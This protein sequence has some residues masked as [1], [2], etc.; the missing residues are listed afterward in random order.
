MSVVRTAKIWRALIIASTGLLLADFSVAEEQVA[1]EQNC[2]QPGRWLVPA[3][4]ESLDFTQLMPRLKDKK[5]V[6][7]GEVHDQP[8]HH[9]WQ[10]QMVSALSA[11]NGDIA[12]AL[13][14]FPRRVQP[15]LDRWVAGELTRQQFLE[16]TD[17]FAVWGFAPELYMPLF[18]FARLNNVRMLAMNVDR[19]LVRKVGK[20]GWESVP[21]G[22]RENVS[23]PAAPSSA[24]VDYLWDIFRNHPAADSDSNTTSDALKREGPEFQSFVR[25]QTF[26]DRAMADAIANEVR[27]HP[28]RV[29]IAVLGSGHVQEGWGVAHQLSS[30]GITDVGSLLPWAAGDECEEPSATVADAVFGIKPNRD[31][32]EQSRPRLGVRVSENER[33]LVVS[34]VET[35]SIA[36]AAGIRAQDLLLE[37]AGIKLKTGQDLAA[38]VHRQPLGTWLPVLVERDGKEL[39]FI[40]RF[41]PAS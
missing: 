28:D 9:I 3:T 8:E 1:E 20:S 39:Q 6:L 11:S 36:S 25:S 38:V 26:W 22:E 2:P 30:Q 23:E 32:D 37:A 21:I 33:G 35:D 34:E 41:P 18:E 31:G 15:I 19:S 10:F 16:Q 4:N 5:V 24:Y 40:A 29:V 7:L 17:W 14:A 13:E 27:E 12:I